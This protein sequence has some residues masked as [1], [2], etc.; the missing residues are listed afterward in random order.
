MMLELGI[1]EVAVRHQAAKGAQVRSTRL[2]G[3]E[4][5][6]KAD[7]LRTRHAAGSA[8]ACKTRPKP[9]H[10]ARFKTEPD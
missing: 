9:R 8:A 5:D 10:A 4:P 6:V 7:N 2:Q 1:N 3:P